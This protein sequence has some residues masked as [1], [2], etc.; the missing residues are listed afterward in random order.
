MKTDNENLLTQYLLGELPED[1]KLRLEEEFFTAD[2]AFQ[3]L[4]ALEDELRYDYARGGLTAAQRHQFEQRFLS[5]PGAAQRVALAQAVLET[6]AEANLPIVPEGITTPEEKPSLFQSLAA[7]FRLQ[8]SGLQVGLAAASLLLLL[9][10]SWLLYQTVRLRS[11]VE[12][13]EVARAEQE[14]QRIQQ[15]RQAA[16]ERTRGDQLN[17]QLEAERR[18]RAELEQE[19]AKQK[20]QSAR[21][22]ANQSSASATLLSFLLTPGLSRDI[23]STK[24]LL[25]PSNTTQLRLQLRLKRPGAYPSY[26]A[27]LQTLDGAELWQRNLARSA[28]QAVSVTLPAKLVPPG[29]YVLVLKGKA[30]DSSWEEVDEYHFNTA[31]Q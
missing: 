23:D 10:G 15:E 31:R 16:D 4:L 5:Q 1:E 7:F 2:E 26:Q 24:R 19:L 18:Q 14:Q 22:S 29:D 21:E 13:L 30:A 8:S 3:Q 12:Q 25:I 20:A 28:G 6:V 11:Q 9:G 27:V 17:S